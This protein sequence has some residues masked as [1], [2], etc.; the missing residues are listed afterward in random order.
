MLPRYLTRFDPDYIRGVARQIPYQRLQGGLFPGIEVWMRRDDLLDPLVSGNKAYKLLYNI[1]RMREM[2]LDTI[3]TCGGA[4]S[5][6]I[7][8]TAAAGRRFGF[9]TVGIIRGHKPET[10]SAMLRDAE[11]LGMELYFVSRDQYRQRHSVEFLP[12]V[13]L[14]GRNACFVPEGG[15]NLEGFMGLRLL[16]EVIAE[17]APVEFDQAWLACGTGLSLAGIQAG[18]GGTPVIGLPVLKAGSSIFEQA[19]R[20]LDRSGCRRRLQPLREGYHFGGYARMK[21]QL[22][23]FM[24]DFE[25]GEGIPL[26]PVYTAKLACGLQSELLLGKVPSGSKVLLLHSGGLQGR[27]GYSG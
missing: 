9:K 21:P 24:Q 25:S 19:G 5:N 17:T 26:D 13:G 22:R 14:D 7:H 15:A 27:R 1:Q 4:W 11:R 12:R 3:V 20:W 18:L 10:P 23:Q 16:G 6:H 8:A 2:G